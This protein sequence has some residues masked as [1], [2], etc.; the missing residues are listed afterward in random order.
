[1]DLLEEVLLSRFRVKSPAT[2]A[3]DS[4]GKKGGEVMVR[5]SQ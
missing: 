3:V 1:M 4:V 5:V 2:L